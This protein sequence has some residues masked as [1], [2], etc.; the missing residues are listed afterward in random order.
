MEPDGH[1]ARLLDSWKS[2]TLV[3]YVTNDTALI[4]NRVK[5]SRTK[6][7]CYGKHVHMSKAFYILR[8]SINFT[9]FYPIDFFVICT[10]HY[11][12]KFCFGWSFFWLR[13][14]EVIIPSDFSNL[15]ATISFGI[16]N[17]FTIFAKNIFL[18]RHTINKTNFICLEYSI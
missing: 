13:M 9:L 7:E 3:R 1:D 12:T 17:V 16:S 11:S 6:N 18:Y 14:F 10:Q 5:K 8:I 15:I 2:I 4:A